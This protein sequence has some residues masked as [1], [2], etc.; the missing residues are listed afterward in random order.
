MRKSKLIFILFLVVFC[1]STLS[2][3]AYANIC[4]EELGACS[5]QNIGGSCAFRDSNFQECYPPQGISRCEFGTLY[6]CAY[7]CAVPAGDP[8]FC[9]SVTITATP[10]SCD[11]NN[12]NT[13]DLC[14]FD[15]CVNSVVSPKELCNSKGYIYCD[16]EKK[17][18]SETPVCTVQSSQT[19]FIS[20]NS[21]RIYVGE[22]FNSSPSSTLI[23][24]SAEIRNLYSGNGALGGALSRGDNGGKDGEQG[25]AGAL[26]GTPFEICTLSNSNV[27][28]NF[29]KIHIGGN[30]SLDGKDGSPGQTFSD[31]CS[32]HNDGSCVDSGGTDVGCGGSGGF[33]GCAGGVLIMNSEFVEV[34]GTITLRGGSGGNGGRGQADYDSWSSDDPGGSGGGGGGGQGGLFI[35]NSAI[36]KIPLTNINISGGSGGTGGG[37]TDCSPS[38]QAGGDGASGKS[39]PS[40]KILTQGSTEAYDF[41]NSCSDNYDNDGNGKTDFEDMSCQLAC[42]STWIAK[43]INDGTGSWYSAINGFDGCCGDDDWL[44]GDFEK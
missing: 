30:I 4:A 5:C 20:S 40:P 32:S 36:A 6:T 42:P 14:L 43:G 33:G 16:F 12:P 3:L 22:L 18:I 26:V 28:F 27:T 1:T 23:F 21:P 15:R 38:P 29:K 11:D 19:I 17:C 25:Y 35:V 31:S 34:S 44:N 37:R 13:N 9:E 10:T 41:F 24:S 2:S 7:S 39:G 8:P